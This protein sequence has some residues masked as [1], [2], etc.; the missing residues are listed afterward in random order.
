MGWHILQFVHKETSP[1][2]DLFDW[3][4]SKKIVIIGKGATAG[5]PTEES[6]KKYG[7]NPIVID[8]KTKKVPE[9]LKSADVIV[10]AVGKK[11]IQP[12]NLKSGVVLI[13]IGLHRGEDG[14]LHG[15]YDDDEVNQIASFYTPSPGGVGPINLAYLFQNLVKAAAKS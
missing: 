8:R 14:K 3:L 5:K 4:K 6:L 13:G 2:S 10:G 7:L 1:E 11:V 15:D 9:I 12:E